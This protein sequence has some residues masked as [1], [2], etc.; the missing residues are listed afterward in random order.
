MAK[1]SKKKVHS[2][3]A[4]A[5]GEWWEEREIDELREKLCAQFPA[6]KKTVEDMLEVAGDA[7]NSRAEEDWTTYK[8]EFRE[9]EQLL[10]ALF[11]G[12][13]GKKDVM[14]KLEIPRHLTE[15]EKKNIRNCVR[16]VVKEAVDSAYDAVHARGIDE[17]AIARVFEDP[18]LTQSARL[19]VT[20]L[21]LKEVNTLVDSTMEAMESLTQL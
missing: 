5:M 16:L 6:Q 9:C 10:D 11:A 7:S 1:L 3:L 19:L 4:A 13:G 15:K 18:L 14:K 20:Q 2:Q 12:R 8:E 21:V 17:A